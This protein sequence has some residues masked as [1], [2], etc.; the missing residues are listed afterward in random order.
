VRTARAGRRSLVV[1]LLAIG[2]AACSS[3]QMSSWSPSGS[4]VWEPPPGEDDDAADAAPDGAAAAPDAPDVPVVAV[5]SPE[6]ALALADRSFMAGDMDAAV[7]AY[8]VVFATGSRGDQAYALYKIAWCAVNLEQLVQASDRMEQL[9]R[10]L[11]PPRDDQERRLRHEAVHDIAVLESMRNDVTPH[12][13]ADRLAGLLHGDEL[14]ESLRT[15]AD[16]YRAAGRLDA[17]A[18]IRERLRRSP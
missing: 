6:D 2:L 7:R 1:L 11:D 15:L 3:R 17:E 13:S 18:V 14:T 9:L 4:L 12:E 16:Q 10:L 8:G 5:P